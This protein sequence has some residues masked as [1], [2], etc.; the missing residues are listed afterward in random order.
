MRLVILP[1]L[2]VYQHCY[3]TVSQKRRE[4]PPTIITTQLP[5]GEQVCVTLTKRTKMVWLKVC[6]RCYFVSPRLPWQVRAPLR[7]SSNPRHPQRER[8]S[9]STE[10]GNDRKRRIPISIWPPSCTA[11][12]PRRTRQAS[13]PVQ[14]LR[15]P[16]MAP[17]AETRVRQAIGLDSSKEPTSLPLENARPQPPPLPADP[18]RLTRVGERRNQDDLRSE[19][20]PADKNNGFSK[21]LVSEE[22][23]LENVLQIY[24][25]HT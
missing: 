5:C 6:G 8:I 17:S 1:G 16:I 23:W 25:V 2:R 14:T 21:L 12:S 13:W 11:D 4:G 3:N 20:V 7:P 18:R 24:N 22:T 19:T 9:A 15:V 10:S